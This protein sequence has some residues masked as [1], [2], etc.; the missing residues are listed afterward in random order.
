MVL[1]EEQILGQ[2]REAYLMGIES[3]GVSTFFHHLFSEALRVGKRIR[4]E[5]KIAHSGASISSA[6][7][8][9][10]KKM[11]PDLSKVKGMVL[12]A[13]HMGNLALQSLY[14]EGV[15]DLVIVNRNED[16][17]QEL[18]KRFGGTPLPWEDKQNALCEVDL[19]ISS[20]S[21]PH[22][23]IAKEDLMIR[24]KSNQ[25]PLLLIDIAVPRD[26]DPSLSNLSNVQVYNIDNLQQIA[27]EWL[28]K[29]YKDEI[30]LA[31]KLIHTEKEKFEHWLRIREVQPII[32]ALREKAEMIRQQEIS[33][34][35][36]QINA[37][38]ED[39]QAIIKELTHKMIAKLLHEPTIQLK[40]F[41]EL[42]MSEDYFSM[43]CKLYNLDSKDQWR[44]R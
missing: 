3:E 41:A 18:A 15:R 5:T 19:V 31:Q 25:R 14:D 7:V 33:K 27:V 34:M 20:T 40:A 2:V 21:A 35:K 29:G 11:F 6:A 12:G 16:K 1:G 32:K 43:I 26:V 39:G 4:S 36:S 8:K 17:R 38:G 13:G 44:I 24:L 9:L 23:V 28:Y 37:L 22:F 10:V 30:N 42:G